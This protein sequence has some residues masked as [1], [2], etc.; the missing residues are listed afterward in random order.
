MSWRETHSSSNVAAYNYDAATSTLTVV[1]RNGG[2]YE[3]SG[4]G[5]EVVA[6][7]DAAPSVGKYLSSVVKGKFDYKRLQQ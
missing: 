3:Y 7:L 4:V 6:G 2:R 5:A 1:F